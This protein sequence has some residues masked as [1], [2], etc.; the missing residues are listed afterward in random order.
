MWIRKTIL[1]LQVESQDSL[2]RR[3]YPEISRFQKRSLWRLKGMT[4]EEPVRK[5]GSRDVKERDEA[6]SCDGSGKE[7]RR[8]QRPKFRSRDL[9][10]FALRGFFTDPITTLLPS[11]PPSMTNKW[12][13]TPAIDFEIS[14]S[15]RSII[16]PP[17]PF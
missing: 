5:F 1:T 14:N 13:E 2:T 16:L 4:P 12:C 9:G 8:S 17:N 10:V 3:G 15:T 11:T 7:H 6:D